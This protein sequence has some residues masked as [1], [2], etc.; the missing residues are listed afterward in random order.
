M[1]ICLSRALNRGDARIRYL[2]MQ[3]TATS[4]A[5]RPS[6]ARTPPSAVPGV[7]RPTPGIVPGA[8]PPPRG[9]QCSTR[10]DQ[11][12]TCLIKP[13]RPSNC[14][15]R[16][17]HAQVWGNT[18]TNINSNINTNTHLLDPITVPNTYL[19]AQARQHGVTQ[20][21]RPR[22]LHQINAKPRKGPAIRKMRRPDATK[23]QHADRTSAP[24]R[25][26]PLCQ[27]P[28]VGTRMPEG[29]AA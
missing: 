11:V 22:Y 21:V 2:S 19:S 16:A 27:H 3:A 13:T 5:V 8:A 23:H 25:P 20:Q 29:K 1:C 6:A 28:K 10:A 12:T 17:H 9:P 14:A 15:Q 7:G 4:A 24:H 26:P 18:S